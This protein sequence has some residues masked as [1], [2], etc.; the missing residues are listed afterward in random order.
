M[1][2]LKKLKVNRVKHKKIK[3]DLVKLKKFKV[4]DVKIKK[5]KVDKMI[6]FYHLFRDDQYICLGA[7]QNPI[8]HTF[9]ESII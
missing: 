3:V 2:K 4:D 9:S 5:L 8:K 1:V 7:S 6:Y